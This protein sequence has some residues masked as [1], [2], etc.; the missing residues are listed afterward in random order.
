[1]ESGFLL[2]VYFSLRAIAHAP[3]PLGAAQ[4]NQGGS[5]PLDPPDRPCLLAIP[6]QSI[7]SG[8]QTNCRFIVY[9][10]NVLIY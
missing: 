9:H 1:M 7:N 5:D 6:F 4:G 10:K 3:V 8:N 2:I